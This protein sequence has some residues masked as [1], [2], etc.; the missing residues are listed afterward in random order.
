MKIVLLLLC[1]VYFVHS[2]TVIR[3]NS[4]G[5]LPQSQKTAVVLSSTLLSNVRFSVYSGSNA[6]YSSSSVT[7]SAKWNTQYAY[8]YQLDFTTV[9]TIG[10]KYPKT[11]LIRSGNYT[12]QLYD[13]QGNVIASSPFT[14]SSSV[15]YNQL[16]ENSLFY[17]RAQRDGSNIGM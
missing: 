2:S 17:Y 6:V 11:R 4:F 8:T 5:F 16:I 14:I 3:T 9:Q 13:A 15:A 10:K 12:I 1:I 7:S